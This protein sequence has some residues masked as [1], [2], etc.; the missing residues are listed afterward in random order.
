MWIVSG[1]SAG[2]LCEP[3]TSNP[4]WKFST[5]SS[6]RRG[7]AVILALAEEVRQASERRQAELEESG[8]AD[9]IAQCKAEAIKLFEQGRYGD[10]IERFKVL[11]GLNR[12]TAT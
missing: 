9:R 7:N 2:T 6:W 12:R 1:A 10:C 4:A 5:A 8:L 3:R 11:A